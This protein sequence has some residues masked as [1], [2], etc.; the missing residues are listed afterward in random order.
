MNALR[1]NGLDAHVMAV[2]W[3]PFGPVMTARAEWLEGLGLLEK[4]RRTEELAVVR[5]I[6]KGAA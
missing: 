6:R 1:A 3:V 2:R 5:A 4:G